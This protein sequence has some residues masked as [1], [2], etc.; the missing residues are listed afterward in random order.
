[1]VIPLMGRMLSQI[2]S[3]IAKF[4]TRHL[5]PN[6]SE[7]RIS[8]G[9]IF[10]VIKEVEPHAIKIERALVDPDKKI[11]LPKNNFNKFRKVENRL[12]FIL[13]VSCMLLIAAFI[14]LPR[15]TSRNQFFF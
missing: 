9:P 13:P 2:I 15:E 3:N 7:H 10:R 5:P 6:V 1:M 14:G 8:W 12:K 11:Q 4:S